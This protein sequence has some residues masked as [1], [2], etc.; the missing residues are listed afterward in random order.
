MNGNKKLISA[1]ENKGKPVTNYIVTNTFVGT[2]NL[3]ELLSRLVIREAKEPTG[4]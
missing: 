2:K 1:T 4:N 3:T